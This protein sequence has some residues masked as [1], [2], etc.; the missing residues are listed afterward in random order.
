MLDLDVK[1]A[2]SDTNSLLGD[3]RSKKMKIDD[4]NNKRLDRLINVQP[5]F[6]FGTKRSTSAESSPRNRSKKLLT[7]NFNFFKPPPLKS[8]A[9][10]K[11]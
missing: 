2:R 1:K 11:F 8:L 5:R 4:S 7:P 10:G 3:F 6:E 9:D